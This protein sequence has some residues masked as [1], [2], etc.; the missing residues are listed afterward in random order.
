M[1]Q[2]SS[3][4]RR[5]AESFRYGISR[6]MAGR[7][8]ADKLNIAILVTGLVFSLGASL[9]RNVLI[10]SLLALISYGLLFWALFR[11]M[12]RNT[13]RRYE[14]NRR[15]LQYWNCLKDRHH[16]YFTCPKC[17]QM[18]RVPR[19]KGKIMITCPRCGEKFMRKS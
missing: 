18:S 13:Y 6:L 3:F 1:N 17:R 8:G 14:E 12:S 9:V 15:F 7:Y 11:C 10:S 4:L 19:G 2:I 5:L 16:R